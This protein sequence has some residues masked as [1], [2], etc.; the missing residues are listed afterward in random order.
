MTQNLRSTQAKL[1]QIYPPVWWKT[2]EAAPDWPEKDVAKDRPVLS[3]RF[4]AE[5]FREDCNPTHVKFYNE[6][7]KHEP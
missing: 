4:E 7:I 2:G 1:Q 3:G 6:Q 5:P